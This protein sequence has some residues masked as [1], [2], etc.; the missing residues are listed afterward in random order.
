MKNSFINVLYNDTHDHSKSS[1]RQSLSK[2]EVPRYRV[3]N[4]A[5]YRLWDLKLIP[6]DDLRFRIL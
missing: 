3:T 1:S 4:T 5:V 6:A 2:E